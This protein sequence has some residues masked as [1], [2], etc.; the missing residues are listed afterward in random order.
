[1][2]RRIPGAYH[3][4][5]QDM[6]DASD[7]T[8]YATPASSDHSVYATPAG[9]DHSSLYATPAATPAGTPP[10]P[11]Y[12]AEEE[13]SM[14]FRSDHCGHDEESEE[15]HAMWK[16]LQKQR[17]LPPAMSIVSMLPCSRCA[18]DRA[19]RTI[20]LWIDLLGR[21][22][23]YIV[24]KR[25]TLAEMAWIVAFSE[26]H[27]ELPETEANLARL[28]AECHLLGTLRVHLNTAAGAIYGITSM[29]HVALYRGLKYWAFRAASTP[30]REES[31]AMLDLES[32][33]LERLIQEQDRLLAL[34]EE[35]PT[36]RISLFEVNRLY[37][38][39]A[40]VYDSIGQIAIL[41]GRAHGNL[42][43]YGQPYLAHEQFSAVHRRLGDQYLA[44][45]RRA[46]DILGDVGRLRRSLPIRDL[47][48]PV[49]MP[50]LD[51]PRIVFV[52]NLNASVVSMV[53]E[54]GN[55]L[56]LVEEAEDSP[57]P[58]ARLKFR[59]LP[60]GREDEE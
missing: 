35:D 5:D 16:R 38:T 49:A 13:L 41:V 36:F 23:G 21:Q 54:L 27:P 33:N 46:H 44:Y 25:G 31:L 59:H 43:P 8:A 55:L 45:D 1:M 47:V 11:P 60:F 12:T 34:G 14:Q 39:L 9:S 52:Q 37:F 40:D 32:G 18:G 53:H 57:Y 22:R 17:A 4:S 56:D 19:D 51:D 28:G 10:P 15:A 30:A 20:K 7:R 42:Y 2:H 50:S 29:S 26:Q 48:D 24:D 3:N 6:S 58:T